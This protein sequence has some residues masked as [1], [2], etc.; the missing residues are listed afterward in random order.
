MDGLEDHTMNLTPE[1]TPAPDGSE[2]EFK[3]A[4]PASRVSAIM[5]ELNEDHPAK[6]TVLQAHYFDTP[7]DRL[8]A[9]GLSLR[10]RQHGGRWFQTLKMKGKHGNLHRAEHEVAVDAPPGSKMPLI[11]LRRHHG[12]T[13]GRAASEALAQAGGHAGG[14]ALGLVARYG[15]RVV[16]TSR[17]ISFRKSLIELALDQGHIVAGDQR[18]PVCEL[19]MELKQGHPSALAAL[20]RRWLK[21]HGLWLLAEAKADRG[22][23]LAQGQS[24]PSATKAQP[25]KLDAEATTA[26]AMARTVVA[27]CLSHIL[28]NAAAVA[29]GSVDADHVHQ[30]RVGLRRL[31]TALQ[32]LAELSSDMPTRVERPIAQVFRALGTHRD[33]AQVIDA[34]TPRLI[35][36]GARGTAWAGRTDE[37]VDLAG[38]VRQPAFQIALVRAAE[39]AFSEEKRRPTS[40]ATSVRKY[41]RS[42]LRR[43][44]ANVVGNGRQFKQ[45]DTEHQHQVRKQLKRLRYLCEFASPLFDKASVDGYLDSLKP[46]Q[47]ALGDHND[48]SVAEAMARPCAKKD[49]DARFAVHWLNEAQRDTAR[50]AHRTLKKVEHAPRF[51]KNRLTELAPTG[52]NGR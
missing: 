22:R 48:Y 24:A 28:P 11:D 14:N 19:E 38:L 5:T 31:R 30:L 34:I 39:F 43:L 52:L 20:A 6:S 13:A 44:H 42:R 8:A 49:K 4:V 51:W 25:V 41:L 18:I 50:K 33:Q 7:D 35:E 46:A 12:T 29:E 45:L 40:D 37:P 47:E 17:Q 2:L 27:N 1:H 23:R 21:R 26:D 16:R 36:A 3:L 10:L 9:A 15:T 32:E